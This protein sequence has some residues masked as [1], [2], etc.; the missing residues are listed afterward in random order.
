M[1]SKLL[2]GKEVAEVL[3]ISK[4]LAYRLMKQG[5]IPTIRFSG[6]T[7]RVKEEDLL[8]WVETH[9]NTKQADFPGTDGGSKV[10]QI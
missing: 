8:R 1:L 10:A 3:R 2:T 6:K 4:A 5:D 9:S 7:T